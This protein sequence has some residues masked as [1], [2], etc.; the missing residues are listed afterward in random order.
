MIE[1]NVSFVKMSI[2]ARSLTAGGK[3]CSVISVFC[4]R[5]N[6]E[7]VGR[8]RIP[9]LFPVQKFNVNWPVDDRLV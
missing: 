5:S 8:S 4:A 6:G 2:G 9:F 1:K 7:R 3:E